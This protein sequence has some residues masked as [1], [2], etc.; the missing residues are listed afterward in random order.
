MDKIKIKDLEIY[1][2][3][4]VYKEENVLG[5]KFL[6]SA[7][8][9]TDTRKAGQRDDINCSINYADVSHFV[10][11][12]MNQHTYKLIEAAAEN[13][14]EQILLH[15]PLVKKIRLEVKKPWAPI[16]LPLDTVSVE[17]E[18]G[19]HKAY[20]GLGS[21]MGDRES[22]LKRAIEILGGDGRSRAGKISSFIVT[23]PVGG[24]EQ[25]DFLNGAMELE[26]LRTP[27]ELLELVGKTEEELKRVRTIKWGPRTIDVDILLYDDNVVCTEE[28][29]I[30]HAEMHRR[31]FVLK[32]LSEIA[33]FVYHPLLNRTILQLREDFVRI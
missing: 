2:H 24:V 6:I 30:P 23:E 5:Q 11:Q 13:M 12:F 28:L 18:R 17:I 15:F 14:A 31:A 16:L 27:E 10:K 29:V 33:P 3:H 4:G 20:L 19:W 22:Y 32:P 7:D 25:D 26:T 21:N 9:Y 8:L 1:G